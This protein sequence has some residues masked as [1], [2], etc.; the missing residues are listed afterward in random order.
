MGLFKTRVPQKILFPTLT[1]GVFVF[2]SVS[3]FLRRLPPPVSHSLTHS[4]S[5]SLSLSHSPTHSLT[6]SVMHSLTHS[7]HSLTRSLNV[8]F[9]WQAWGNVHCQGVGC[10]PWRPLGL[11]LFCVAGVGQCALSRARMYALASLGSPPLLRGRRGTMCT[12]KGSD[13]RPGVPWVSASFAWQAW[14]NVHCQ[15]FGCTPWRPLGLRLFCVAGVGQCALPRVWMYALASLG[16]PPLL[17]GRRGTMCTAKGSDVRPGVPWVSAA[18][19]WQAWDNVHCQGLGCTPWRPLGLRLFG[20]AGVAQCALPRARM[21][22]LG[23]LGSPPLLRG[24]R[25]TMC[26]AKGLDVRPGVPWVSA[27]FAW[28]AWDNSLTR[29]LTHSF[30]HS[31]THPA[32]H[33]LTHSLTHTLSLTHSPTHSPTHSLTH[34]P[35]SLTPLHSTPLHST[36]LHSTPLHFTPLHST[37]SL[38]QL[39]HTYTHTN[40][41]TITAPS[42]LYVLFP[43]CFSMP[44]LNLEKLV[45]CGVISGPLILSSSSHAKMHYLKIAKTHIWANPMAQWCFWDSFEMWWLHIL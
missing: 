38:T 9:A 39:E 36:S 18:F 41:P 43:S 7:L 4:L 35:H 1:C 14:D 37:H 45:T 17:R 44:S 11:R 6:H 13:V 29:S 40:S 8:H 22:A 42:L 3:T 12:V 31:L 26:T 34:S 32:T 10:T 28:Q 16:S 27:S 33:S 30:T 19:A 20:V 2:S 25:G 24:R 15:G 5:H 21:Y 23:S